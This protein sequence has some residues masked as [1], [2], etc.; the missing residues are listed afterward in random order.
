MPSTAD[1]IYQ[2][3]PQLGRLR[4]DVLVGD[5]WKQ[6]ELSPRERSLV[7]CAILAATG[8]TNELEGHLR[9]AIANGVTEDNIR[10]LIVQL[11]FYA[12]W[13]SAVSTGWAALPL[14]EQA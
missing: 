8:R 2:A 14:L 4:E 5:V 9:R 3:V 7:T 1:A 13:P 10:G 11:A 12:G 6:P